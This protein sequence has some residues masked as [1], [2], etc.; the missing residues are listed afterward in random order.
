MRPVPLFEPTNRLKISGLLAVLIWGVA[1]LKTFANGFGLSD[2][3]AFATARGE[4]FVAT[5]DNPSA[6]Y[7][8]PAGITQIEG[9]NVRMGIYAIDYHISF[10]PPS[11]QAN[12]GHTYNE[13]D[14][15]AAIPQFFYTCSPTNLPMSFGLGIYSPFG[16]NMSWPQDTGFRSVALSGK[17]TYV[18]INPVVAWKI[19]PSLSIAAGLMVNYVDMS[20]EQGLLR[21]PKPFANYFRFTGDGWSVG[22]NLGARWQ[23]LEKLSFGASF[24]SPAKVTLDGRTQIAYPGIANSQTSAHTDFTF[25]MSVIGGVSYRPTP[26]WNLEFDANYTDWSSFDSTTIHQANPPAPFHPDVP[27]TLDWQASWMYEFGVTRYFDNGWH[28]SGGYV[29]NENSVPDKYYTPLAADMDRHFFSLGAG[30]KGKTFDF[31]VAYQFGYGPTHTVSDS[32]PSSTPGFITGQ[33]ADGK[34]SFNSQ[35]VIVSVGMHF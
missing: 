8:N 33:N 4:A 31:D 16:G 9:S 26:K 18:T 21:F 1:A 11:G 24:R 3:D 25:P 32:K 15:F 13:Q 5:A 2:Q 35:A 14:N 12:T 7:Y 10:K 30:R 34:Y 23:P 27:V 20:L 6:I 29:F 22:Y 28:V 17:L 19:S